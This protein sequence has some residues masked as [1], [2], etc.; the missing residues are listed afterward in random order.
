[1]FLHQACLRE[2]EGAGAEPDQGDSFRSG[3]LQ[4][5]ECF[6]VD[7]LFDSQEATNNGNVIELGGIAEVRSRSD[8]DSAARGDQMPRAPEDLPIGEDSPR[9]VELVA[10]KPE[11]VDEQCEGRERERSR[12]DEADFQATRLWR[13]CRRR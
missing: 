3:L 13:A 6:M 8:L 9:P 4:K 5:P 1:M 2:N 7:R 10:R 12:E 11:R